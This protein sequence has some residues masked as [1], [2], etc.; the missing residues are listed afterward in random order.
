ML[1]LQ[2]ILD[3]AQ[4]GVGVIIALFLAVLLGGYVSDVVQKVR[5]NEERLDRLEARVDTDDD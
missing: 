2:T 4:L 1:P 5:R 3:P